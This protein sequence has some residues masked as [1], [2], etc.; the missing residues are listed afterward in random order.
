MHTKGPW[1]VVKRQP[2]NMNSWLPGWDIV[3]TD[4]EVATVFQHGDEELEEHQANLIAAAPELLEALDGFTQ[5]IELMG[6]KVPRDVK[7]IIAR[8]KG[9]ST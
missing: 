3:G 6:M 9:L 5:F 2:D 7:H 4:G 1:K 8:A